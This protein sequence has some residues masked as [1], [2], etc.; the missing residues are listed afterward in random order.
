MAASKPGG[1]RRLEAKSAAFHAA[2]ANTHLE[3]SK[4]VHGLVNPL[5]LTHSAQGLVQNQPA[6]PMPDVVGASIRRAA[7]AEL[8]SVRVPR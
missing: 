7:R 6:M 5:T 4:P 2:E 8:G 3:P 1:P